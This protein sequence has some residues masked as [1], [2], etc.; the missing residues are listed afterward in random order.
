[1]GLHRGEN[2]DKH[3]GAV[4]EQQLVA[5]EKPANRTGKAVKFVCGEAPSSSPELHGS[6][7]EHAREVLD[8]VRK[9]SV[10]A[11]PPA[12]HP[13]RLGPTDV[14]P[15]RE[16]SSGSLALYGGDGMVLES[17]AN[18]SSWRANTCVFSG[19]W[20]YEVVS[21]GQD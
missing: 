18:F 14:V 3:S 17:L 11:P 9:S 4:D 1:M 19:K 20:M 12:L 13:G 15:D 5:E 16:S 6:A 10:R 21:M 2:G 7:F 8:G